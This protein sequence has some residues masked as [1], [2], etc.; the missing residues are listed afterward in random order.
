MEKFPYGG[1]IDYPGKGVI[2]DSDV[3]ELVVK[4]SSLDERLDP[5]KMAEMTLLAQTVLMGIYEHVDPDGDW[6][7]YGKNMLYDIM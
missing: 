7:F 6:T 5:E 4:H 2:K 1:Y 3:Y